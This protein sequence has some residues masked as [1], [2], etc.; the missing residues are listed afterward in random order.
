[1]EE[2]LIRDYWWGGNSS[3]AENP[4]GLL[5][6]VLCPGTGGL[7]LQP[8]QND[9]LVESRDDRVPQEGSREHEDEDDDGDE[10]D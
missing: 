3:T 2:R 7:Q 10:D 1:V 6:L 4:V 5:I 8:V 9:E